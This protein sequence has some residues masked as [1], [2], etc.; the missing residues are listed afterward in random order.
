MTKY[1]VVGAHVVSGA[2]PGSVVD[3]DPERVNIDALL[4]ARHIEPLPVPAPPKA[5]KP[6][7]GD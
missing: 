4:K 7:G 2:K 3:L 1:K 6:K 5:A